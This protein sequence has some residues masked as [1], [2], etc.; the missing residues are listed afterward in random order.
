MRTPR[1]RVP[2]SPR[3]TRHP[4]WRCRGGTRSWWGTQRRAAL[5]RHCATSRAWREARRRRGGPAPGAR[6]ARDAVEVERAVLALDA[7]LGDGR[8]GQA[9]GAHHHRLAPGRAL[10]RDAHRKR[11]RRDGGDVFGVGGVSRRV[12]R[13]VLRNDVGG[14]RGSGRAIRA[15]DPAPRR[16]SAQSPGDD[17]VAVD[18]RLPWYSAAS[19]P[20]SSSASATAA[21]P[22]RRF[23]PRD[24]PPREPPRARCGTRRRS[25]S[26]RR[27]RR[28]PPARAANAGAE[29]A[30]PAQ[31]GAPPRPRSSPPAP[32]WRR[33]SSRRRGS[34]GRRRR[35]RRRRL[36]ARRPRTR[37]PGRRP[38]TRAGGIRGRGPRPV[39]GL[40][41]D[42]LRVAH[43][44]PASAPCASG[45]DATLPPRRSA[46][47]PRMSAPA[48]AK[49]TSG[50]RRSS[51]T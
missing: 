8:T 12:S 15:R 42:R 30:R 50:T 25:R 34:P 18:G 24:R 38:R 9:V 14:G 43:G 20:P 39:D 2:R 16:C 45:A 31:R 3:R 37:R 10:V 7:V 13:R 5:P 41:G 6:D 23:P 28:S 40:A 26:R 48:T 4:R 32:P 27:A 29:A 1:T 17:P 35:R 11:H 22:P 19:A 46:A 21:A 51:G 47:L 49:A 36:G 33:R 44:E